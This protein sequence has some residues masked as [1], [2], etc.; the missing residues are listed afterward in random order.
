MNESID[1]ILCN[2]PLITVQEESPGD[3]GESVGLAALS[4]G[5][6]GYSQDEM[7]GL[8]CNMALASWER[9]STSVANAE[10]GSLFSFVLGIYSAVEL[11]DHMVILFDFFEKQS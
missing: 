5:L 10:T 4:V 11:P 8:Y 1:L 9:P 6:P 2:H 7:R 3:A